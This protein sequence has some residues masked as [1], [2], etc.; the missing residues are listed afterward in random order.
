MPIDDAELG[1]L[2]RRRRDTAL[3]IQEI[4]ASVSHKAQQISNLNAALQGN[5]DR[6][7][8][9]DDGALYWGPGTPFPPETFP[10][11]MD[12][13][14]ELRKVRKEHNSLAKQL[15]YEGF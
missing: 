13:L 14:Q 11:L 7:Q 5:L 9:L 8:V 4:E 15:A 3:R 2:I 1:S 12:E 6:F 10:A